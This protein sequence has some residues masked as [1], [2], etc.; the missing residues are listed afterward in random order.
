MV[1]VSV[2]DT[3]ISTCPGCWLLDQDEMYR[4]SRAPVLSSG[5][6]VGRANQT[7]CSSLSKNS[8]YAPKPHRAAGI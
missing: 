4:Y 6:D 5:E 7:A 8:A 1:Q 3:T 2:G